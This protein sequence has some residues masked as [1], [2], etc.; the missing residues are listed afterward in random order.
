[1]L[2]PMAIR[3]AKNYQA[4]MSS[5]EHKYR[6]FN[7]VPDFDE[8]TVGQAMKLA[9]EAG[10]EDV[11]RAAAEKSGK[12][13]VLFDL[14]PLERKELGGAIR[15]PA[16]TLGDVLSADRVAQIA[17]EHPELNADTPVRDAV[18]VLGGTRGHGG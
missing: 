5:L 6:G 9:S 14:S 11:D 10:R 3:T 8:L 15:D 12:S 18:S 13:I 17:R 7:S 2:I 1:M 4:L 16:K